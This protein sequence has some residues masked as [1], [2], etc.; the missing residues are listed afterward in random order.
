MDSFIYAVLCIVI[1]C[2]QYVCNRLSVDVSTASNGTWEL[3][4]GHWELST[5]HWELGIGTGNWELGLGLGP[6]YI[7][8]QLGGE[9]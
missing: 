3:G 9:I 5:G 6:Q 4:T 7:E 2:I 8:C 1:Y